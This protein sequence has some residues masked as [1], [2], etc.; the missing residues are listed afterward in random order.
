MGEL[1]VRVMLNL[2]YALPHRAAAG[3]H[4]DLTSAFCYKSQRM[5]PLRA[6]RTSHQCQ[7]SSW[8]S[9]LDCE[10]ALMHG[11][12]WRAGGRGAKAMRG[13]RTSG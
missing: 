1:R 12:L 3:A 7:N 5:T 10:E 4:S 9:S 11:L 6:V 8:G 13:T 2:M